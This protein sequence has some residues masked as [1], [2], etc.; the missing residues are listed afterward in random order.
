MLQAQLLD[1]HIPVYRFTHIVNCQGGNGSGGLIF[2][3]ISTR[4]YPVVMGS[5]LISTIMFVISTTLSDLVNAWLD[6][7]IRAS[8]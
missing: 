6:P 1:L 7:R 2:D 3:S 5:V 4:N 8:L